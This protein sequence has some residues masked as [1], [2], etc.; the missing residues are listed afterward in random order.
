[1]ELKGWSKFAYTVVKK[2]I[3]P[4]VTFDSLQ[5]NFLGWYTSDIFPTLS[6]IIGEC[7]LRED[8]ATVNA[9]WQTH[10]WYRR[11]IFPSRWYRESVTGGLQFAVP[12]KGTIARGFC[13]LFVATSRFECHITFTSSIDLIGSLLGITWFFCG[14][15]DIT[16]YFWNTYSSLPSTQWVVVCDWSKTNRKL[17]TM[18]WIRQIRLYKWEIFQIINHLKQ[19]RKSKIAFEE[20]DVRPI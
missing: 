5:V 12:I 16:S 20:S 1:M 14:T 2:C 9:K 6:C 18:V 7:P 17:R 13:D 3:D 4:K 19:D 10:N 8:G 11:H 15:Y